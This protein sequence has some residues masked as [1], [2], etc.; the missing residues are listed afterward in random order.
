LKVIPGQLQEVT[1]QVRKREQSSA[2]DLQALREL[3]QQR[4]YRRGW[5]ERVH[6]ARLAKRYGM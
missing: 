5:A 2:S 3:A 1:A 4:G 6:Q